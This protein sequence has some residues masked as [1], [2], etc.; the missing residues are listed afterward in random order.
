MT[1]PFA[2]ADFLA[3]WIPQVRHDLAASDAETLALADLLDL[4]APEDLEDWQ[5]LGFG[6]TD[7]RGGE[8]LRTILAGRYAGLAAAEILCC[9]GAQEALACAAAALLEPSDH[10]VVVLPVYQPSEE[11]VTG[12]CEATGVPLREERGWRLD[13]ADVAAA[14]RPRTRLVLMNMP[15][16]PTGA[17][18]DA[19]T[20]GELVALCRSRGIWLLVDEVYRRTA[21]QAL[22]PAIA[23]LYERGITVDSLSKGFGLAGL[24]VGWIGCRDRRMLS[25]ALDAKNRMSSCL[26]APSEVLARVALGSEKRIIARSRAACERGRLRLRALIAR[27]SD[28]FED[29]ASSNLAF[30]FPRYRGPEG[31]ERFARDLALRAGILVLPSVLWR[32]RLGPT[33]ADR[34]RIGLGRLRSVDA[35]DALDGHLS[36]RAPRPAAAE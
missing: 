19:A 33:P 20:M 36:V 13:V 27:H 15:N 5:R 6:Y 16:N 28:R 9:A 4:A 11:A 21:R 22:A 23:D 31:A 30:A 26:T 14:L 25:A 12:R 18:L 8:R 10:A 7:P 3:H 24:R 34:L 29:E 2:L 35:L 32:S 1:V 17:T